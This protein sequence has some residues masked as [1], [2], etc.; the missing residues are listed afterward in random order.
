MDYVWVIDA[1]DVLELIIGAIIL[2]IIVVGFVVYFL[3]QFL[4]EQLHKCRVKKY[5]NKKV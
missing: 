4:Q 3:V 2:A 5:I 1:I